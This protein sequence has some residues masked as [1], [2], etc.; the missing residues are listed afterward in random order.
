MLQQ[1]LLILFACFDKELFCGFGSVGVL[2]CVV[3]F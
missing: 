1:N 3:G 2:F